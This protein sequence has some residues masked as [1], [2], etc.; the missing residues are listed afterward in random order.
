M[1]PVPGPV[2]FV[3]MLATSPAGV[4]AWWQASQL[5]EVG[6][7]ALGPGPLLDGITTILLTP[8]KLLFVTSGPWQL[9]QPEL[10]PVWL[11]AEL[12]KRAPF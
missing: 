10:M 3:A 12:L 2:V 7:W 5:V 11:K 8:K 9:A 1:N 6:R 4:L